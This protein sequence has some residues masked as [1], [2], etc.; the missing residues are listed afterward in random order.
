MPRVARP[1]GAELHWEERGAGP[2][3][4]LAHTCI[5]YPEVFGAVCDELVSDHR[6]LT[7]HPR[8]S[9]DSTQAGPYD[10]ETDAA[11]LIAVLEHAGAGPAVVLG[12]GDGANRAV[13]AASRRPDL[14]SHVVVGVGHTLGARAGRDTDALT[15]S[16][17]VLQA[18]LRQIESDYRGALHAMIAVPNPDLSHRD[19]HERID[20]TIEH[21]SHEAAVGR[22][23]EW[24][25]DDASAES[26]AIGDRLWVLQVQDNPWFTPELGG[27]MREVLPEAHIE[28]APGGVLTRPGVCAGVV[29]GLTAQAGALSSD[30]QR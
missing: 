15:E 20:R 5:S 14:V 22:M 8:G 17:S 13:R 10:R 29:R 27:R 3:V 6:V 30:S 25:R 18:I 28:D 21:V 19:V 7:Y 26:A 11:D 24:I 16:P 1:D 12:M 2:S 4:L 9:G 23:N